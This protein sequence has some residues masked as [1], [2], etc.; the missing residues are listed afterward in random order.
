MRPL[1]TA[2]LVVLLSAVS[3]FNWASPTQA[4][5][6]SA[7]TDLPLSPG[8][9]LP[10]DEAMLQSFRHVALRWRHGTL[11]PQFVVKLPRR[12]ATFTVH[13]DASPTQRER[14]EFDRQ[15]A[16]ISGVAG[17]SF[18][19]TPYQAVFDLLPADQLRPDN[20]PLDLMLF[21]GGSTAKTRAARYL[22]EAW[23]SA[24]TPE[25][26]GACFVSPSFDRIRGIRRAVIFI[27]RER[28]PWLFKRCLDEELMQAMGL[29][30]DHPSDVDFSVFVDFGGR[31]RATLH[32]YVL[33]AMLYDDRVKIGMED[34]AL[35]EVIAPVLES[36]KKRVFDLST[37]C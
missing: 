1:L 6:N 29:F 11:D 28:G 9:S 5:Q 7:T 3:E 14:A 22:Q 26:Y 13:P 16:R 19:E 35:S 27:N 25:A 2:L 31:D 24:R 37:R 23:G 36:T 21:F 8:C 33:L 18:V 15:L 17:V 20:A 4:A 30:N 12:A 32:D 34:S 10:P